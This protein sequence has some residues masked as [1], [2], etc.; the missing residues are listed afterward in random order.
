MSVNSDVFQNKARQLRN[1]VRQHETEAQNASRKVDDVNVS[2]ACIFDLS[3][4]STYFCHSQRSE[5]L[6]Q[7]S[8]DDTQ[9]K[10]VMSIV[11]LLCFLSNKHIKSIK[12]KKRIKTNRFG[13]HWTC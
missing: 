3:L 6:N 8:L 10:N 12:E 13:R 4:I 7:G 11:G 1:E 9:K 5:I 2:N